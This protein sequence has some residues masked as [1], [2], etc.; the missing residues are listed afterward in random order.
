MLIPLP[1]IGRDAAQDAVRYMRVNFVP[2]GDFADSFES[3]QGPAGGA[4][5]A[6]QN[7]GSPGAE[8]ESAIPQ[9]LSTGSG[10]FA[11]HREAATASGT[12]AKSSEQ[13]SWK[14]KLGLS[15]S[16]SRNGNVG[17]AGQLNGVHGVNASN[18][19]F[20]SGAA[21]ADM[22]HSPPAASNEPAAF[23]ITAVVHDAPWMSTARQ[24]RNV[25]PRLPEAGT[26]PVVLGYCNGTKAL[27][28]VPEGWG[29][30]RLAGVPEPTKPDGS[31][32]DGMHPLNGVTD[33]IIAACTAVMDV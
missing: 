20:E 22:P 16:H 10:S 14:R 29:A 28:M 6:L 33:V 12:A 1:L 25:D 11:S 24:P 23:R 17:N 27:E 32:L 8:S 26:F 3:S 21:T 7:A 19:R 2:F 4:A 5:A 18:M 30:L 31:P 15:S 9:S 13:S